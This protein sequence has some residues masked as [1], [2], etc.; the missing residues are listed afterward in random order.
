M[1]E[2]KTFRSADNTKTALIG[3]H[4]EVLVVEFYE[5][6]KR[7]G[8]IEYPDKAYGY[9]QDAAENWTIGVMTTETIK[10]YQR[11]A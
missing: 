5:N 1:K 2:I 6:G 10:R 7:I 11:A 9:V 4:D 8:E 3:I